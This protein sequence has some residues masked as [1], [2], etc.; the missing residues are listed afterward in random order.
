MRILECI[1]AQVSA[2]AA[3]RTR[4]AYRYPVRAP[5]AFARCIKRAQV[6]ALACIGVALR[7]ATGIGDTRDGA[8]ARFA[9]AGP[10]GLDSSRARIPGGYL[11][12][13]TVGPGRPVPK[14]ARPPGK[15]LRAIP[16]RVNV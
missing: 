7:E 10:V 8:R 14:G 4:R 13:V 5:Y 12:R 3:A 16:G 11:N 9:Q 6:G 2:R 1:G 15:G